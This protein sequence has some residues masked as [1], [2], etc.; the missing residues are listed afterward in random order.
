MIFGLLH[1]Y[2]KNF[3]AMRVSGERGG[4]GLRNKDLQNIERLR[5]AEAQNVAGDEVNRL[6]RGART[7][8]AREPS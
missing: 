8:R 6:G 2:W 4:K 3:S 1:F 5:M 7:S